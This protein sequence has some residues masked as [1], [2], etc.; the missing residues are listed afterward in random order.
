VYEHNKW[1]NYTLAL[2]RCREMGYY[3]RLFDLLD[4]RLLTKG[5]LREFCFILF[6]S[7]VF[8]SVP[9]AEAD[10]EG[11]FKALSNIVE[12]EQGQWDPIRK[13]TQKLI[14]LKALHAVYNPTP[15]CCVLS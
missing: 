12:N 15:V 10:W 1:L 8:D 4:E 6:G 5:E 11:F 3:H 14:N 13:S 7:E 2:H 9:E